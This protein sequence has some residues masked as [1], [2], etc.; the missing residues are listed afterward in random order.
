MFNLM[1]SEWAGIGAIWPE[2]HPEP[3]EKMNDPLIGAI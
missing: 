2:R 1:P 3:V